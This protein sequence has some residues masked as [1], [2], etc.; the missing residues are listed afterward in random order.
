MTQQRNAGRA[1]AAIPGWGPWWRG[2]ARAS[3]V[4]R[5]ESSASAVLDSW[6]ARRMVCRH[7]EAPMSATPPSHTAPPPASR[8]RP[9]CLVALLAGFAVGTWPVAALG[10]AATDSLAAPIP[11]SAPA[12]SIAA[13]APGVAALRPIPADQL[14]GARPPAAYYRAERIAAFGLDNVAVDSIGHTI[15]YEN[16]RFRH[17]AYARGR[18]AGQFVVAWDL[19]GDG[20]GGGASGSW[21]TAPA[22]T[23]FERRLGLVA[24]AV[25][26][27]SGTTVRFGRL[28]P[29][30]DS[31][32][33]LAGVPAAVR[34]PSDRDF[35]TPPSGRV[36]GTTRWATDLELVPL[37]T[38][39]L[40]R[41][42]SPV[43]IRLELEPRIRVNPWPGARVTASLIIPVRNDFRFDPV[44]PDVDRTRPGPTTLEQFAWLPGLALL[45][46][47]AGMF[48]D[49]RYGVS[50][51]AARPLAGGAFLLDAQADLTGYLAF[52]TT[53]A[54]YSGLK[55][56]SGFA[57]MT[58]RP[59][60]L[61]LGVRL[62]GE[63]FLY[64]DRGAELE[65]RRTFEDL[66]VAFFYQ[67]TGEFNV[68]GVRLLVPIPPSV[69]RHTST[70]PPGVPV[71][72]LP[73]DRLPVDY[74]D[75]STPVGRVLKTVASREDYLRQLNLPG[76]AANAYRY[77]A[78]RGWHS[79]DYPES[80]RPRVSLTGMT[81]FI[82][83]P[84]CGVMTDRGVELGYNRIPKEAAYD[85]R[86]SHR[87][88]V[89]YAALG[90]L[91][92]FEAGLRW[93][94]IPG[95][96]AF[97]DLVPESRLTDQDRMLSG[98]VELLSP[99][100]RRPGLAVGIEDAVGTRRF[101]STYAVTGIPFA[102]Q[103][104]HARLSLG[105][106]PRVFKTTRHILD[107]A[108]GA[109]EASLWRP[110]AASLE[111]DSEKWNTSLGIDLGFGVRARAALLDGSHASVGAGW[112]VG[113]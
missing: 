55:R 14:Y 92:R 86:G 111:Y 106:A 109:F 110:V 83:T 27:T 81:G 62:R 60:K 113:L 2:A 9:V 29:R 90:F 97:S 42:F 85:N 61:D 11:Q 18:L 26:E 94:V 13:P 40:G 46:G 44:H 95:L 99:R 7:P 17:S 57:G 72:F 88:D 43:Q 52:P 8:L 77:R 47:T 80:D 31:L 12:D 50:F 22:G 4:G 53:G 21:T 78:G 41:L 24:A 56:F 79:A 39:E 37:F 59:P 96:K 3:V 102:Y 58:W 6:A 49:N 82:N 112:S 75:E 32:Q 76:L 68:N 45:S 15:A 54:E 34:Y 74:V 63:R 48:A 36:L 33:Q 84:W 87:N 73:I 91:P 105:Y 108:F 101:H 71:R 69:R 1:R 104:W 66:D 51:G 20:P 103:R 64:G 98:R 5:G 38:Y 10:A 93:T 23:F 89:Y 100:P 70:H 67:R 65:L 16:R 28:T 107:G 19:T 25:I 35:P 30:G